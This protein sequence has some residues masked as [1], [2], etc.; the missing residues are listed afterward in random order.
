MTDPRCGEVRGYRAHWRENR[1]PTCKP[2][3]DAMAAWERA[4]AIR[5][6]INRGGQ[7]VD[8]LGTRRRMQALAALGW[9]LAEI[10]NRVGMSPQ[11]VSRMFR[12]GRV[13]RT[14]EAKVR[15]LYDELS[16]IPGPSKRAR[17][18]ALRKGWAVPLAWDDEKIDDPNARPSRMTAN[19]A[20]FDEIAVGRAMRG[21][22]IR[23]RP[24]ERAEAV[25]RLTAQGLSATEI[26]DRLGIAPRSV[27]RMRGA[28]A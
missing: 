5:R 16:M 17:D 20:S 1:L 11:Q 18:V 2:C 13:H 4:A 14:T 23:L 26:G 27:T 12:T 3:R 24:V 19:R 10:G 25:R 9:P 21:E 15:A 6:Y 22:R 7:L 8:P 28:A